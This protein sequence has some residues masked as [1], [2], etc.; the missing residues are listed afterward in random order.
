M[1]GT[2]AS[3]DGGAGMGVGAVAK[4]GT[5]VAAVV[6]ADTEI[7]KGADSSGVDIFCRFAA[8]PSHGSLSGIRS[9]I[10][11]EV[12]TAADAACCCFKAA[13]SLTNLVCCACNAL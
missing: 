13:I 3:T 2:C 11:V 4:A 7:N 12:S 6:N 9:C 5:C 1:A 10:C 8:L